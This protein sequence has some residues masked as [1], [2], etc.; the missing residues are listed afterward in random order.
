[1]LE[2][3][4]ENEDDAAF[5]NMGHPWQMPTKDQCSELS[6]YTKNES[7]ITS[8]QGLKCVEL[9][10]IFNKRKLIMPLGG[11]AYGKN[12]NSHGTHAL[13]WLKSLSS[14]TSYASYACIPQ[15]THIIIG[16]TDRFFGFNVRAVINPNK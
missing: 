12:L 6:K 11:F 8:P 7:F 1:M 16:N 9:K 3:Q 10:S 15:F 14:G 2:A 4:L 5:A 13:L